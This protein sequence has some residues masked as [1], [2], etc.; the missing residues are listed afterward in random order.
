MSRID[1][2][3]AIRWLPAAIVNFSSGPSNWVS[4]KLD[5]NA[6]QSSAKTDGETIADLADTF[7]TVAQDHTDAANNLAANIA[8]Q[9]I[10]N[11]INVKV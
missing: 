3:G 1:D 10:K 6:V 2:A 4:R 5:G 8:L 7:A 11:K 9:R